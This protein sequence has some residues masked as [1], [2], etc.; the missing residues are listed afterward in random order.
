M[1]WQMVEN[2]NLHTSS[3]QCMIPLNYINE[4]L[5][6]F[7]WFWIV[8][9]IMVTMVNIVLFV[10][11]IMNKSQREDT[12]LSY[13]RASYYCFLVTVMF[14]IA[15]FGKLLPSRKGLD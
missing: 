4:K 1:S 11:S 13:L 3:T 8:I 14:Y 9:L 15:R 12:I 2:N 5:F 10:G 6:L 7:L